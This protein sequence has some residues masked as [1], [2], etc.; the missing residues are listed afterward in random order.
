M[1]IVEYRK[2][3][4]DNCGKEEEVKGAGSYPNKWLE[5]SI[6]E[7]SGT[8]GERRYE[9]E[10]CGDKCAIELMKK[11]EKIPEIEPARI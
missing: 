2:L 1:S 6:Y 11:L 9:K 3:K 8:S 7:W 10:V 4:C 5:I